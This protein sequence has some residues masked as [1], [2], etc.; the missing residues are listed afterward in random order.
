M[1]R[2]SLI[3]VACLGAVFSATAAQADWRA[4]STSHFII[5]SESDDKAVEQL[6]RSLETV[7][8][9]MRM[10]TGLGTDVE[11]VKVRIYQVG[12]EGDVQR[13]I[14]ETGSGIA[15]FYSSNI[16]GP[17][18]VTPRHMTFQQGDF[19]TDLVLH[20][21]YAH[22]FMLQYFPGTYPGW[23]T[24]GFAELIGS[25]RIM[26]D[27][28]IAYGYPAKHRGD[29]ISF[30]WYPLQDLLLTPPEKIHGMDWYGEGWALTHFFTFSK[31]RS[32]QLREYLAALTAGKSRA[33]AAKVFGDL[34]DLNRE[35]S[36]YLRAGSFT[37]RAVRVPI[38]EPV[39]QAVR[40]LS[41]GEAALVPETIAFRD[42][43]LAA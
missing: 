35:A 27:G 5:Y 33:D 17:F 28:T 36:A 1:K 6:A 26:R 16:L 20:H 9:L 40:A 22:H 3:V 38:H 30:D 37:Y 39:I 12:D 43:D 29:E 8:G 24:E 2:V 13:A 25:S 21:E 15:G 14:G 11:P 41:P 32:K 34:G 31:T 18:A 4:F 23:Y 7:D 42:D 19:T 10:A